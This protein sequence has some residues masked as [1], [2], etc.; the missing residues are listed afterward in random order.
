MFDD[1][2]AAVEAGLDYDELAATLSNNERVVF[3]K[4]TGYALEARCRFV[5]V[6]N[7]DCLV[8]CEFDDVF[9][10]SGQMWVIPSK[11]EDDRY[12][13]RRL[14]LAWRMRANAP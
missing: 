8:L 2:F 4:L 5:A 6:Y 7:L 3:G 11:P 1:S 10:E 9:A 12:A 13:V 14:Y